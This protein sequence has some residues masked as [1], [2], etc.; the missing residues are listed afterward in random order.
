MQKL[1]IPQTDWTPAGGYV[2]MLLCC[3]KDSAWIG[4]V[5]GRIWE[6]ATGRLWDER[7]GRVTEVQ[8]IGKEIWE[9]M[10]TCGL[11]DLVLAFTNLNE[12][13]LSQQEVLVSIS[14][15]LGEIKTALEGA[16]SG[17]DL[18]DDLANVWGNLQAITAVLGGDIP[19]PPDPL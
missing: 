3:P 18:E 4:T 14:T 5:R 1:P 2:L 13:L 10:S 17:D 19:S 9:S 11:D 8:K 7:T 15:T 16:P 6:L 12:I